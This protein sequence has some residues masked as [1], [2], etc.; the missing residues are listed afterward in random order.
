MTWL[1]KF[2]RF[3]DPTRKKSF[4]AGVLRQ[5]DPTNANSLMG[6]VAPYAV[7]A[8]PGIGAPL[9]MGLGATLRASQA[10]GRGEYLGTIAGSALK[11]AGEAGLTRGLVRGVSGIGRGAAA[12]PAPAGYGANEATFLGQDVAG[13]MA[14]TG[15]AA[16]PGA[17]VSPVA[18]GAAKVAPGATNAGRGGLLRGIGTWAQKNP[19]LAVGAL[20]TAANVYGASQEG[21]AMDRELALRE[22]EM[23]RRYHPRVPYNQ[24]DAE[25]QRLRAQ[26]GYGG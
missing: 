5:V 4:T 17:T 23:N 26:Y 16:A 7:G 13:G 9:A 1:S 10:A 25:R 24:W 3:I 8:I 15:P 22:E 2:G 12:P 19:E 18:T 11:G 21:A 14:T 20:S 6:K